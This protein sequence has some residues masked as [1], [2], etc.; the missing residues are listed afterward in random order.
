MYFRLCLSEQNI[1][2]LMK[3]RNFALFA[4]SSGQSFG[5]VDNQFTTPN[6]ALNIKHPRDLVCRF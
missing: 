6:V 3:C 1:V 2:Q 4:K 5:E